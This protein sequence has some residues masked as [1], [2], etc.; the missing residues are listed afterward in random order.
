MLPT[1][2]TLVQGMN[3]FLTAVVNDDER[4]KR[5]SPPPAKE[6]IERQP[7]QDRPSKIGI[8]QGHATFSQQNLVLELLSSAPFAKGEQQHGNERDRDPDDPP[9]AR[10]GMR[11][12]EECDNQLRHDV[13]DERDEGDP[14]ETKCQTLSCEIDAPELPNDHNGRKNSMRES[15]PK[16]ARATE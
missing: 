15:R 9:N 4:S 6:R 7:H 14:N 10:G 3:S 13:D 2:C 16:P 5:I 1:L 8:H 11:S 12:S